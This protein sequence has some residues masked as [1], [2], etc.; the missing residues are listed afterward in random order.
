MV[1]AVAIC[2]SQP[3]FGRAMQNLYTGIL[4]RQLIRNGAGSVR[5]IVIYHQNRG[6]GQQG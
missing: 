2:F 3:Q 5:R 1:K 6:F 4:L